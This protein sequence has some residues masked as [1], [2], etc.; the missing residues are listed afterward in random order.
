MSLIDRKRD[1]EN[2][3]RHRLNKPGRV[4]A[5]MAQSTTMSVRFLQSIWQNVER[6]VPALAQLL[7]H[8]PSATRWS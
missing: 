7:L 4:S 8:D 1:D 3:Q 2:R 5:C 6:C